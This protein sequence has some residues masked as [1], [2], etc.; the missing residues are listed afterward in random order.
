MG[1]PAGGRGSKGRAR[2]G[3]AGAF[4]CCCGLGPAARGEALLKAAGLSCRGARVPADAS[5]RQPRAFH[6]PAFLPRSPRPPARRPDSGAP[7]PAAPRG[8]PKGL[9][10]DPGDGTRDP[11]EGPG[12][13]GPGPPAPQQPEGLPEAVGGPLWPWSRRARRFF[14]IFFD[15]FR[16]FPVEGETS[17]PHGQARWGSGSNPSAAV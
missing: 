16:V 2:T 10:G 13:G 11:P 1:T 12:A 15:F 6:V 9:L 4:N 7:G 17:H 3:A 14:K 5:S 8:D